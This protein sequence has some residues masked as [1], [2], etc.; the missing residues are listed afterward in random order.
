MM[1]MKNRYD[2]HDEDL[3]WL[4]ELADAVKAD[5][6]PPAAYAEARRNLMQRLPGQ[7]DAPGW[8]LPGG[9][10]S[11]RW[12]RLAV[13]GVS[14]VLVV[15]LVLNP[16][17]G[18][19]GRAFAAVVESLQNALTIAF[20]ADLYFAGN[21]EPTSV[22]MAFRKPGLQRL[23]MTYEGATVIQINDTVRHRGLI[24]IPAARQY[25]EIDL[26]KMPSTEHERLALI[27]QVTEGLIS[28]PREAEEV[29]GR[30]VVDGRVVRGYRVGTRT[31]WIDEDRHTLV[32]VELPMG[33]ARM[34]MNSFRLDPPELEASL[35]STTPPADYAES[36]DATLVYDVD[37]VGEEDLVA[38]LQ[39]MAQLRTD[40]QFPTMVNPMEALTLE[41]QGLL[42]VDPDAD[43]AQL[44]ESGRAFASA[45]QRA[46][47]FVMTMKPASGWHYAGAGVTLGDADTPI[48]WWKPDHA[49]DYRVVWGDLDITDEP[50]WDPGRQ[51]R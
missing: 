21:E 44:A 29:L 49:D 7:T 24:L 13:A 12:G 41:E 42:Q 23:E 46:V 20:S 50:D 6:Y 25:M 22:Q 16:F 26:Q 37:Q 2:E 32:R 48:A 39:F 35:F 28:L 3:R 5:A 31:L 14:L 10:Q 18:G 8:F 51:A 40:L 30:E 34:V 36:L 11:T 27:S 33:G 47:T 17:G 1:T 9:V 15:G 38:F 4:N 45:S 19:G 43:P